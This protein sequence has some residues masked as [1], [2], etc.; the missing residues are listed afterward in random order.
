MFKRRRAARVRQP[1]SDWIRGA[2]PRAVGRGT[3]PVPTEVRVQQQILLSGTWYGD[4]SQQTSFTHPQ[5]IGMSVAWANIVLCTAS[6]R[7][8][9]DGCGGGLHSGCCS[10]LRPA[11]NLY[12]RRRAPA[13][14]MVVRIIRTVS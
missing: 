6:L 8:M 3:P 11:C 5:A 13:R 14:Q 10:Q 2:G 12:P 4:R 1:G 9:G 7:I